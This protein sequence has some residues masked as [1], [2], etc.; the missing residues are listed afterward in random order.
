ML[1]KYLHILTIIFLL[2]FIFATAALA[3][4]NLI[5]VI[6]G[7]GG[8]QSGNFKFYC[9]GDPKW[10]SNSCMM[11]ENGC[12]PTSL[13]MIFTYFGLIMD[14]GDMIKSWKGVFMDGNHVQGC[15]SG[16]NQYDIVHS[17]WFKNKGFV[18]SPDLV[19]AKGNLDLKT[20][21]T[22]IDKGYLVWGSA[23]GYP[24]TPELRCN[25]NSDHAFVITDVD[26]TRNTVSIRDPMGC[27]YSG[28]E[29]KY[30]RVKKANFVTTWYPVFAICKRGACK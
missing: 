23:G 11:N 16:A 10:S 19:T 17:Q 15:F 24:C 25:G 21:K 26:P 27:D 29:T 7:N 1:K 28:K 13:A 30:Q 20:A 9:Q 18:H 6:I 22:F 8:G 5:R 14:P 3:D 12:V 4:N 2:T